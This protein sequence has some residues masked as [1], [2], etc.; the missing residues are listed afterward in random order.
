MATSKATAYTKPVMASNIKGSFV[1]SN[2]QISTWSETSDGGTYYKSSAGTV[3]ITKSGYYPMG[4][5]G[6]YVSGTNADKLGFG[7]ARLSARASGSATV[8]YCLERH[9]N[10]FA[11]SNSVWYVHILWVKE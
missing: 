3:V 6:V 8:Q 7:R 5:V 11:H 1:V 9:G 4:V 2:H 10:G